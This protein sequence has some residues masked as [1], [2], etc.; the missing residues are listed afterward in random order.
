MTIS[1]DTATTFACLM[2][3]VLRLRRFLVDPAEIE[4]RLTEHESVQVA[5]VVGVRDAAGATG[6]VG[7]VV[8]DGPAEPE[9]LGAWCAKTLARF[10]VPS[11]IH[12][13]DR[14]ATTSGTNGSKIRAATLREW[15]RQHHEAKT[16][17]GHGSA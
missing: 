11:A 9:E 10:K 14:M 16:A 4:H 5:K 7:F 2:G 12:V 15:A 13:I 3:D 8:L 17:P 6:A 1:E